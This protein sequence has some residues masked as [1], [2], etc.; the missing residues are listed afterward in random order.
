MIPESN[1]AASPVPKRPF[2]FDA[3]NLSSNGRLSITKKLKATFYVPVVV[4]FSFYFTIDTFTR[5][6]Q[7]YEILHR[8]MSWLVVV[9][10]EYST[11][12]FCMVYS[13]TKEDLH[14]ERQRD[15]IIESR[16][17]GILMVRFL[18]TFQE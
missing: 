10:E 11:V 7:A 13:N 17:F 8:I 16:A 3:V 5:E 12:S 4:R 2:I 9:I 1:I 18:C 14:I 6:G 15:S